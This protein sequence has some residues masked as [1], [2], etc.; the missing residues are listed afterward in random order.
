MASRTLDG[1]GMVADNVHENCCDGSILADV[2]AI[3]AIRA[4]SLAIS[5]HAPKF[6]CTQCNRYYRDINEHLCYHRRD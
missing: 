5:V 1:K 3:G 6:R 2:G 4:A